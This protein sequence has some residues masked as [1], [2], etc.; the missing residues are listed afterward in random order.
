MVTTLLFVFA[1]FNIN[2]ADE[3]MNR[4]ESILINKDYTSLEIK[5]K[6]T[7]NYVE[8][9]KG[10]K[11]YLVELLP[12]NSTSRLNELQSL[13]ET[14]VSS[15]FTF[16]IKF[17]KES[18]NQIFAKYLVVSKNG[19]EFEIVT[20]A[21]FIDNVDVVAKETYSY[22]TYATKKGL[23]IQ[24]ITDAQE[25]GVSHTIVDVPVNELLLAEISQESESYIFDN[26]N[27]YVNKSALTRLDYAVKSYSDAGM[28]VFLNIKLT[29]SGDNTPEKLKSLYYD[30][31]SEFSKNYAFN[32]QNQDGG[33]YLQG[34]L[35]FIAG[36]YTKSDRE[37]GFAGSF[38]FGYE[39]NSNRTNY[40]MGPRSLDSFLNAYTTAFRIADTAMRS[41]YSNGRVY[42]SLANNFEKRVNSDDIIADQ[43]LDYAGRA[44]L[45]AFNTK[46]TYSGNIPWNLAINAYASNL[47][48][49]DIWRDEAAWDDYDTHYITMKNIDV[50]SNFLSQPEFLYNGKTRS[51]LISEFG[52]VSGI[53][54]VSASGQ[55]ASIVYSFYKASANP[56]IE[57]IIYS[58]HVDKL[59]DNNK[60]GLWTSKEDS[61]NTPNTKKTAYNLFK[62][63]DT[64]K[65]LE[66][67]EFALPLLGITSWEQWI[68][69]FKE[70]NVK[71][72]NIYD[73]I[74]VTVS[75]INKRNNKKEL[76][77]F[78][79][80]DLSDFFISDNA[81]YLELRADPES[82]ISMLYGRLKSNYV[83]DYMGISFSAD[84]PYN[85]KNINYLSFKMKAEVPEEVS[86][87][88]V[89]VRMYS[90][91]NAV[92]GN[93]TYEGVSQI[94]AG[95][96]QDVTFKTDSVTSDFSEIDVIKVWIKPYDVKDYSTDGFGIWI[97]NISTYG[98][99]SFG[100]IKFIL[101]VM[102]IVVIAIVLF[103]VVII[104]RNMLYVRK[105][106]RRRAM[107]QAR[108]KQERARQLQ[109]SQQFNRPPSNRN[110]DNNT[111][112]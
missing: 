11:I 26:K 103:F 73:I 76:Y 37:F 107:K 101:W 57:A 97:E 38:I 12:Y 75:E 81:S 18:D 45:E 5:G 72:R 91:G 63:M 47:S 96:W 39:V 83:G 3:E 25:L 43:Q 87:V 16:K 13:A 30:E 48:N 24:M 32:T 69:N 82:N 67:S 59:N 112:R 98:G 68:P 88:N 78:V 52:A 6:L 22:P 55:A 4:I 111:R 53:A 105:V 36:R 54:E 33:T 17:D 93:A 40:N 110:D 64:A 108:L 79:N 51:I 109:R 14:N 21:R 19:N 49:P 9:N 100:I 20:G 50:L 86:I 99:S 8:A 62:A 89:M 85:F 92:D 71:K 58:T 104:I 15:N 90:H 7:D 102:L 34:F 66:S 31:A 94:E 23:K 70:S 1:L 2:A 10:S 27:F 29:P 46:L 106:K 77:E 56:M 42:L 28:Q 65:S 95:K 41:T 61:I 74:P 35:K 44:F 80:G 60:F 84:K